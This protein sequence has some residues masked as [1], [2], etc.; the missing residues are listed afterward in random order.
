[1]KGLILAAGIGKRLKPLTP[2]TPKA[3]ISILN[4]P[5][6]HYV[7]EN[8]QTAGIKDL[9]IVIRKEDQVKFKNKL[10]EFNLKLKFLF[11]PSPKGTADAIKVAE[12]FIHGKNFILSW[13]DFISKFDYNKIIKKHKFFKPK[14]TLLISKEKGNSSG[15]VI[16]ND[17]FITKIVEKP[18]SKISSWVSAGVMVLEPEIFSIL[19]KIKPSVQ[20]EYHI[21]DALQYW[22]NQGKKVRFEKLNTW[23]VNVNTNQDIKQAEKLIPLGKQF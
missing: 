19:K 5:M 9:G 22:I 10:K 13:C 16:F 14:A 15:Q 23:R 17:Q 4:K 3:L 7:I 18:K 1:M 6:I 21:A 12:K 8:Y 20:G 11:Q 2:H